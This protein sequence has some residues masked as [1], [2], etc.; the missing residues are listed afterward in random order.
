[1]GWMFEAIKEQIQTQQGDKNTLKANLTMLKDMGLITEDEQE[2]LEEVNND[3][4]NRNI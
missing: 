3:G 1:M 4:K 2:Q